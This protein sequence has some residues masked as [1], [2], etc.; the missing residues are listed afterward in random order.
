MRFWVL[1]Y[2]IFG[3]KYTRWALLVFVLGMALFFF[4]FVHEAFDS[5]R[6][7]HAV[8]DGLPATADQATFA[9]TSPQQGWLQM[10]RPVRYYLNTCRQGRICIGN[11]GVRKMSAWRRSLMVDCQQSGFEV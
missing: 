2:A 3:P 10:I 5:P 6:P 4:C 7:L 8:V 9:N 11:W 1:Y